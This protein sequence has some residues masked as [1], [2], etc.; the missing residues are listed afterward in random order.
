MKLLAV[1]AAALFLPQSGDPAEAAALFHKFEK[2]LMESRA[3]EISF[4]STIE[5]KGKKPDK[6]EGK[7]RLAQ[8][9]KAFIEARGTL[10]GKD[11]SVTIVSDGI[12]LRM[13]TTERDN[14]G[15]I[16]TPQGFN[17]DVI[18]RFA[19]ASAAH[20][21]QGVHRL[22]L[23]LH[24][25]SA[26]ARTPDPVKGPPVTA[27]HFKM[28]APETLR[29]VTWLQVQYVVADSSS[30]ARS[31]VALWL[32]KEKLTPAKRTLEPLQERGARIAEQYANAEYAAKF[33]R[34]AFKIARK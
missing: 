28:G 20:M 13:T 27:G 24:D 31:D 1:A 5:M 15:A 10:D 16:S 11:F 25:R 3:L 18:A 9:N 6:L 33:D 29:G 21:I 34:D 7:F 19:H 22:I 12:S 30:G 14:L 26:G 32:E 17:H 4:G 23:D 8:G 2:A